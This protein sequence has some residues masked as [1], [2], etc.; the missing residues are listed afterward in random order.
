M[1]PSLVYSSPPFSLVQRIKNTSGT[2]FTCRFKVAE[3]LPAHTRVFVSWNACDTVNIYWMFDNMRPILSCVKRSIIHLI[4]EITYSILK[5]L[6][7][8][9]HLSLCEWVF[10]K[11]LML[12]WKKGCLLRPKHHGWHQNMQN[13]HNACCMINVPALLS[14]LML[15]TGWWP[16]GLF[17]SPRFITR[18]GVK[19]R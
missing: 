9:W 12:M 4:S 2:E 14:L 3:Y 13:P 5:E 8:Q 1:H 10:D 15:S 19:Y 18:S 11:Y 17:L 7:E 6:M 16:S